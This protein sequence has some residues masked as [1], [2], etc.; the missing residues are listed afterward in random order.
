MQSRVKKRQ[1]HQEFIRNRRPGPIYCL[2]PAS[3]AQ[4]LQLGAA[5]C[6]CILKCEA[7]KK[8]GRVEGR[9]G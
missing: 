4:S 7:S 1:T 2:L 9:G 3:Y 5:G 6:A 8:V